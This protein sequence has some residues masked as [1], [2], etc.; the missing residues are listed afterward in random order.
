MADLRAE[1][2]EYSIEDYLRGASAPGDLVAQS[3][4][5]TRRYAQP[6]ARPEDPALPA[7]TR[8]ANKRWLATRFEPINIQA[9][10]MLNFREVSPNYRLAEFMIASK[11]QQPLIYYPPAPGAEGF[12]PTACDKINPCFVDGGNEGNV[13]WFRMR[14]DAM[15]LA[16]LTKTDPDL[17]P[18]REGGEHYLIPDGSSAPRCAGYS[19]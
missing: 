5:N 13:S 19:T 14:I 12:I 11:N 3:L 2:G 18:I 17:N 4:A 15:R 9:G 6:P 8:E 7:L 16:G 1:M 10:L